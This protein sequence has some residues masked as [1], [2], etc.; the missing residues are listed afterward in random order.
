MQSSEHC[1][2]AWSRHLMDE[3]A[4]TWRVLPPDHTHSTWRSCAELGLRTRIARSS[5]ASTD[6]LLRS[7]TEYSNSDITK[8]AFRLPKEPWAVRTARVRGGLGCDTGQK[9]PKG[10]KDRQ[11]LLP[12]RN[13]LATKQERSKGGHS[14]LFCSVWRIAKL[15]GLFEGRQG[16]EN[17]S[18]ERGK[19][20]EKKRNGS[21]TP[22]WR[23]WFRG[24]D[25]PL[26]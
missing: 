23:G 16:K 26:G 9:K 7:K 11:A 17:G 5:F 1:G 14:A 8:C 10:P 12:P 15:F 18:E 6:P 22:S 20:G 2:E 19:L 21:G 24:V 25:I 4:G 13:T 3:E